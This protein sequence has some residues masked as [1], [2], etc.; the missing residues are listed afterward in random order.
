MGG[1]A[2]YAEVYPPALCAAILQGIVQQLRADGKF[3]AHNSLFAVCE[4]PMAHVE[5]YDDV[6]NLP[7]DPV[8]VKKAREEEMQQFR[9]HGAYEKV[10]VQEA[11][12]VTGKG[13]IGSG[14]LDINK[15]DTGAPEYRSRLVAK[16]VRR[17]K[18]DD[19]FAASPPLEA[20]KAL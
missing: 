5:Y 6:T 14:W 12:E 3:D 8:L 1:K 9:R 7:L 4:E 17:T 15:G 19:M 11:H 10:P 20:K 13:P 2:T 16:E 18:D